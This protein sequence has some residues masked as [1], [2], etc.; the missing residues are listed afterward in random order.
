VNYARSRLPYP[1]TE[2]HLADS[3]DEFI[4]ALDQFDRTKPD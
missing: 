1:V 3:G 4:A 2:A